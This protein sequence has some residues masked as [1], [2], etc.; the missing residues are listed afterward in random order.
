MSK[1]I[2]LIEKDEPIRSAVERALRQN[3]Y[4]VISVDSAI[5]AE[6]ILGISEFDL[7][8]IGA[9]INCDDGTPLYSEWADNAAERGPV[10]VIYSD[11]TSKPNLPEEAMV[12][13]PFMPDELLSKVAV[14]AGSSS[15]ASAREEAFF[16]DKPL[17]D[18]ALD[19]ALGLDKIEVQ[20][21]EVRNESG[22]T[23][24]PHKK[25]VESLVGYDAEI[26]ATSR[27][28][29]KTLTDTARIDLALQSN[30]TALQKPPAIHNPEDKIEVASPSSSVNPASE[31]GGHDFAWFESEMKVSGAAGQDAKSKPTKA[32]PAKLASTPAQTSPGPDSDTDVFNWSGDGKSVSKDLV[33]AIASSVADK[34]L[35]RL[36]TDKFHQ[37]I[38]REIRN[39]LAKKSG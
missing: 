28:T 18:D 3:G 5:R 27:H 15:D 4:E 22:D 33:N 7:A 29:E 32:P 9:G 31:S 20:E 10:L 6:G 11:R 13:S 39:H 34:L 24:V 16:D 14:F 35:E 2:L 30:K 26:T 37:L 19:A 1:R 25:K 36:D 8:V 23:E 21:S 38:E 12:E 17:D